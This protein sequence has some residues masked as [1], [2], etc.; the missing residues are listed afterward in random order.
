MRI[1]VLGAG[2]IGK[3][4]AAQLGQGGE[5]VVLIGRRPEGRPVEA[6]RIDGRPI[7]P[8][9]VETTADTETL[10]GC[11]V[12]LVAVKSADTAG[13]A[14][15]L[16]PAL[17]SGALVVSFQNGLRNA[18]TLRGAISVPVAAG[19]VTYNVFLD[20]AGRAHQATSGKL[21]VQHLPEASEAQRKL[22]EAFA[23]GGERL[24]LRED[25]PDVQAGKLLVNLINGV[26]AAT[27]LGIAEALGDRDARACYSLAILEGSR[28]LRAAGLRPARVTA[29]P[30]AL[31]GRALRLP[32]AWVAVMARRLARVKGAARS[33]TLQDLDRGRRTEIGDLNGAVVTIAREAGLDAPYNR[34]ITETVHAHEDAVLSGRAPSFVS[35]SELHERLRAAA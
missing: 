29:L 27:G 17:S 19:V 34:M 22:Q 21:L 32:D 4:L 8:G 13:A 18:E 7:T 24:E 9:R 2:S 23:R 20:E 28:V 12:V 15:T 30:P 25:I 35:A 16:A 33:S 10:R 31:L 26:C 1:G 14:A 11:S 3:F 6:V 5:D